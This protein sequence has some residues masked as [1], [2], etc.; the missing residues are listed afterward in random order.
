[1]LP[2]KFFPVAADHFDR[3][4]RVSEAWSE[5]I[6]RIEGLVDFPNGQIAISAIAAVRKN[7]P[8]HPYV[9]VATARAGIDDEFYSKWDNIRSRLNSAL[10]VASAGLLVADNVG[11]LKPVAGELTAQM[12]LSLTDPNTSSLIADV[13]FQPTVTLTP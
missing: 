2:E 5:P 4:A 12:F 7:Q 10:Y 3:R 9:E 6:A 8:L 11:I 13:P 1:M